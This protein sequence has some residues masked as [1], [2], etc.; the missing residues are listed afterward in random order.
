M[1]PK[2]HVQIQRAKGALRIRHVLINAKKELKDD[3]TERP[4]N[5]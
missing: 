3:T 2:P 1:K 5:R 4:A